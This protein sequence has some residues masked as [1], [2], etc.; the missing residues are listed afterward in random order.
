MQETTRVYRVILGLFTEPFFRRKGKRN[1][2]LNQLVLKQRVGP[3]SQKQASLD[4][5]PVE[6]ESGF[7]PLYKVLQTSA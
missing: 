2:V 6:V 7:E 1:F 5:M 4:R 3:F